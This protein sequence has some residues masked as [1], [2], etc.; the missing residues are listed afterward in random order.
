[1]L[2]PLV[3]FILQLFGSRLLSNGFM[4]GYFGI[5]WDNLLLWRYHPLGFFID[6]LA[7]G[8]F[9]VFLLRGERFPPAQKQK[10]ILTIS[11]AVML[12]VTA[13][14]FGGR[15]FNR[16][17]DLI[18]DGAV[19]TEIAGQLLLNG[20]NPYDYN[21]AGTAF[22]HFQ[23]PNFGDASNPTLDHYPYPPLLPVLTA[24]LAWFSAV[25]GFPYEG[26][27]ILLLAFALAAGLLIRRATSL[28]DRTWLTILTVGNPFIIFFPLIGFNDI[29]FASCLIAAVT[30][31]ER[32]TWSWAGVFFGLALAAKQT[33]W[34]A[35]PF[36]LIWMVRSLHGDRRTMRRSVLWT[37]G[38][39]ALL[40]GPFLI[41]NAPALYDDL[42]RFVSGVVPHT[43][44]ISGASLWQLLIIERSIPSPWITTSA[45]LLQLA[46]AALVFPITL[47]RFWQRPTASQFFWSVTFVIL[48]LSWINR[49]FYD[50][51][52]ATLLLLALA[53]YAFYQPLPTEKRQS[54]L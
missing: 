32:K 39:V 45:S 17:V 23:R 15:L 43:Y 25:A 1:M 21:F 34:L 44:P 51:Y 29:L 53:G 6:V 52:L 22:E 24:P 28:A 18:H 54:I 26:R 11:L 7:I 4:I 50:N 36:W 38:V 41:W 37:I 14:L 2:E 30:L 35:I 40:Y 10:V 46:V 13:F 48:C 16:T 27:W 19:Q 3:L 12:L 42:V 49:Y 9:L 47:R 8:G 31:A 33:A 20:Q 5:N